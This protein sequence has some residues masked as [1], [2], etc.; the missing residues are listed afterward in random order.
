M[1][2]RGISKPKA[3]PTFF[4]LMALGSM[5]NRDWIWVW[6]FLGAASA[7]HV[8]VG[9][10]GVSW[11]RCSPWIGIQTGRNQQHIPRWRRNDSK[12]KS[13]RLPPGSRWRRS[14]PFRHCLA[15]RSAPPEIAIAARSIYVNHRIAHHLAFD[16][17]P[18]LHVA[19]VCLLVV[20]IRL[21]CSAVGWRFAGIRCIGRH[22]ASVSVLAWA[23]V[24]ISFGGLCCSVASPSRHD[25]SGPDQRRAIATI[26]LVSAVRFCR[27]G[28]NLRWRAA[29]WF[30]IG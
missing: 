24:L 7:F 16:A 14:E 5:V 25:R 15:D 8:L 2:G 21:L 11:R 28:R 12:R 19:S 3:S 22:A 10:V 1:G 18:A 4:V 13:S 9:A 30:V 29:R 26:L 6:P 27:P 23:V 20:V 17:F